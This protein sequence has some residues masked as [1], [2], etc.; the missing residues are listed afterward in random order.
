[1][2]HPFYGD[3]VRSSRKVLRSR[4]RCRDVS[5]GRPSSP[6]SGPE[7]ENSARGV[8]TVEMPIRGALEGL[9]MTGSQA[10]ITVVGLGTLEGGAGGLVLA[11]LNAAGPA[12]MVGPRFS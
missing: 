7:P 8:K 10:G 6:L 1:M 3:H 4:E 9:L 2:W 11:T 12:A 5:T